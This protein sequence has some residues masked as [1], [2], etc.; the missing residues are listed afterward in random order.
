[1]GKFFKFSSWEAAENFFDI[2]LTDF[3]TLAHRVEA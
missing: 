1:M 3:N 2:Y